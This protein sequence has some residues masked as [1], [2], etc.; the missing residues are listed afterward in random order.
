MYKSRQD[1]RKDTVAAHR[2][3]IQKQL[4]YRLEVARA[5]G[6]EELVRKLEA[7]ANYFS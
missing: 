1:L 3:T 7:E 2:A 4:Q 6:D 5:K